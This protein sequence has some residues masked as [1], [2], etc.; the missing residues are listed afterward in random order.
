M[1]KFDDDMARGCLP[2][3]EPLEALYGVGWWTEHDEPVPYPYDLHIAELESRI[4]ELEAEVAELKEFINQLIEAGDAVINAEPMW[5]AE[6][7][8][9]ETL[10]KDWKEG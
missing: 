4:A 10:V 5:I 1:S 3:G 7:D 8:K 9:W 2:T 6:E